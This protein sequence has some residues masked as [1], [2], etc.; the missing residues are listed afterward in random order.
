M[1]AILDFAWLAALDGVATIFLVIFDV[2]DLKY[3]GIA[4]KSTKISLLLMKLEQNHNF[5][6]NVCQVATKDPTPMIHFWFAP[7]EF[8]SGRLDIGTKM[9]KRE[10]SLI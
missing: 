7:P 5:K 4:T 2:P 8:L 3:M 9:L 10:S 1:A 6:L